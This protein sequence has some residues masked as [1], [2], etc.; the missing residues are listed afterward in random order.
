[1]RWIRHPSLLPLLAL[2]TACSGGHH[3][4]PITPVPGSRTTEGRTIEPLDSS[5]IREIRPL[6]PGEQTIVPLDSGRTIAPLDSGRTIRPVNGAA[7]TRE[8]VPLNTEV[9]PVDGTTWV[10][11]DHEGPLTLE[12]LVG[13]ILRYTKPGGTYTN[14]TWQQSSNTITFETNSH[15]AD[16]AGEIHGTRMT[17]TGRNR[18]GV[19]W[20]WRAERH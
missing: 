5:R 8:I 18:Q 19:R 4:Q 9:V 17:G 16:W 3:L 6:H 11:S 1:M 10:G 7:P 15:Y 14:G 2:L 20:D 13:G 12:F